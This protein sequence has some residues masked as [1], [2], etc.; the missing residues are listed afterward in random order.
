MRTRLLRPRLACEIT[1]EGVVAARQGEADAA[2][3]SFAP[4]P[5]GALAPGLVT[6]NLIQR[7]RVVA[8]LKQALDE[9]AERG[10]N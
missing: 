2:M 9:V 6:P 10:R 3:T 5:A 8:A 7:E 1:P 4:L